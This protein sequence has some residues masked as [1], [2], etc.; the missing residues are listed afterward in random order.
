MANSSVDA[1][2][3]PDNTYMVVGFIGNNGTQT[4]GNL[5]V[6]TTF[7]DTTGKVVALN[8]TSIEPGLAPG[9]NTT[10]WATPPTTRQPCPTV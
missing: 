2:Y 9:G 5:W 7:Y 10:F 1:A 8:F 3:S 6:V 4:S